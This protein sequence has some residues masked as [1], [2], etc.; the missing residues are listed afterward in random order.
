MAAPVLNAKFLRSFF[1]PAGYGTNGCMGWI[2]RLVYEF[3]GFCVNGDNNLSRPG[4]GSLANSQLTGSY[5]NM[6]VGWESGSLVLASGSDGTTSAGLP[7][8]NVTGSQPFAPTM[9]GKWLT[10]WQS[11]SLST[12]DS[13]YYIST[14]LNSSSIMLDPTYGGTSVGPSGSVPQLTSRSNI[15]YR[16]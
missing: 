4:P 6:P 12:D 3:W 2:H 8:F 9:V 10:M 14:W 13:I 16:V 11:G 7:Y 15:N 5:L 1:I